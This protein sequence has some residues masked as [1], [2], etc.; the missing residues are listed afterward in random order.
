MKNTKN[1]NHKKKHPKH[2]KN[3]KE[4]I[5]TTQKYEKYCHNAKKYEKHKTYGLGWEAG[6]TWATLAA[7]AAPTENRTIPDPD[8]LPLLLRRI[9]AGVP[10]HCRG[11]K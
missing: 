2:E 6:E 11:A 8:P 9:T 5:T 4:N 1:I 10:N 7:P 3:M